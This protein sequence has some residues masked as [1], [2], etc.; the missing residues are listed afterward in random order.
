MTPTV[1]SAPLLEGVT[2]DGR[3]IATGAR[4]VFEQ[5]RDERIYQRRWFADYRA[6]CAKSFRRQ[7]EVFRARLDGTCA[8]YI[9]RY[10]E[11]A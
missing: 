1:Y 5:G 6:W 3:L 7:R 2:P 8:D 11:V 9:A 10:R 4:W